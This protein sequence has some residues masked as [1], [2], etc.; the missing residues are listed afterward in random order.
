MHSVKTLR[1]AGNGA[2]GPVWGSDVAFGGK[3]NC[4][5]SRFRHEPTFFNGLRTA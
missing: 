3:R 1:R 2:R 5:E 4:G